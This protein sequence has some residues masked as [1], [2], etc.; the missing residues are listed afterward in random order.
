MPNSMV[1]LNLDISRAC[2][3][4]DAA[5]RAR[6]RIRGMK[7]QNKIAKSLNLHFVYFIFIAVYIV[8]Y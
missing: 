6:S 4:A 5:L 8:T 1:T 7:D 3:A 2:S